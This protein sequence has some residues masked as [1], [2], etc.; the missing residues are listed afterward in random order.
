MKNPFSIVIVCK[1]E[2]AV[3]HH[4]LQSA[5]TITDDVLVY[6]NGST[7]DTITIAAR[8]PNVRVHKGAWLGF[9]KTK[10]AATLL[11]KHDWVLSLDADEALDQQLQQQLATLQLNNEKVAYKLQYKNFLGSKHIRWGEWGFDAHIRLFN[12]R[13]ITWNDAPVHEE[14]WIPKETTIQKL[15]GS[16]LHRTV[17]DT[18]T[19]SNK[20][21]KYALLNAEKLKARGK[22]ATFL[23]R[24][25][26][27]PFA[28]VKYYVFMLGFLDGWEGLLCARM[29]S[30]YTFLKY[31]RLHELNELTK[32]GKK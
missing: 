9:G 27:P 10:Q 6:D 1:N 30:Y 28:F 17:K 22:K 11:A 29:T 21:V 13:H 31:A 3:I 20:V 2:G 12:R 18:A 19:Y 23:K 4:V 24:Y 16:V 5:Q 26:S 25:I 14:L 32:V 8:Y 15:S 7:D